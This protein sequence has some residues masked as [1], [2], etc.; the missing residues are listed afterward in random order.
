MWVKQC[1]LHHPPVIT[2]F[3]FIGGMVTIPS[4]GCFMALFHPQ[5]TIFIGG[6]LHHSQMG[7]LLFWLVVWNIFYFS[8]YWE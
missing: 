4:H 5:I 7:G 1:H 2:I 8:I 6:L 3:I